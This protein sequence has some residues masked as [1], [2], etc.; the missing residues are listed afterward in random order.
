MSNQKD[1]FYFNIDQLDEKKSYNVQQKNKLKIKVHAFESYKQYLCP[2][3]HLW[4]ETFKKILKFNRSSFVI[5]A[6]GLRRML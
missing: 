3:F 6:L 1:H 2:I 5:A 4:R